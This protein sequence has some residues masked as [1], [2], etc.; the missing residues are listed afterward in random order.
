MY[1]INIFYIAIWFTSQK[2]VTCH[3][4]IFKKCMWSEISSLWRL[5]SNNLGRKVNLW[6]KSPS[7]LVVHVKQ[8][9]FLIFRYSSLFPSPPKVNFTQ[10]RDARFLSLL[11]KIY[12]SL[13]AYGIESNCFQCYWNDN[14]EIQ[15]I[16][17]LWIIFYLLLFPNMNSLQLYY[18]CA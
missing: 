12:W 17:L 18:F 5:I 7:T 13:R 6:R 1:K 2:S 8:F 11:T 4:T 16:Y 14:F 9:S 3:Y 15:H 10:S